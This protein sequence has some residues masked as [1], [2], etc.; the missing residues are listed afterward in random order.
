VGFAARNVRLKVAKQHDRELT[1]LIS[2]SPVLPGLCGGCCS[3]RH[4]A[5]THRNKL[6]QTA[7][8]LDKSDGAPAAK[9]PGD[10]QWATAKEDDVGWLRHDMVGVGVI[11]GLKCGLG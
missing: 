10:R 9:V 8:A 3:Q 7:S 2:D 1:T 11:V 5:G 6:G 4:H